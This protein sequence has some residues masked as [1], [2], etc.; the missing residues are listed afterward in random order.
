MTIRR[1]EG[2]LEAKNIKNYGI[3]RYSGENEKVN[4]LYILYCRS[5]MEPYYG[6]TGAFRCLVEGGG[7]VAFV[8]ADRYTLFI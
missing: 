3:E 4:D 7:D 2:I 8:K 1:T 6:H 5:T